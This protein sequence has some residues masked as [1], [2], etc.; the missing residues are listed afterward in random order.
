MSAT[1]RALA[2]AIRTK[3]ENFPGMVGVEPLSRRDWASATFL[4]E[5][6]RLRISLAGAGA[7]M[8]ADR[9]IAGLNDDEFD[10]GAHF[11]ASAALASDRREVAAVELVIE[12]LV[13]AAD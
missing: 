8:A 10:L 2:H 6:H 1:A 3:F 5:R 9:F 12:L 7:E 11:V 4:G 13:I